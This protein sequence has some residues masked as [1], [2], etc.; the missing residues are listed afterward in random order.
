MSVSGLSK[1]RT[2]NI[3][4]WQQTLEEE[5]G[6]EGTIAGNSQAQFS[7]TVRP[8]SECCVEVGNQIC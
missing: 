2:V 6:L 5:P 8:A 3:V 7:V 4:S 1:G